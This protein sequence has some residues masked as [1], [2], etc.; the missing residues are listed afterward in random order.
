MFILKLA[1]ESFICL[2]EEG[3]GLRIL[4]LGGEGL[5]TW[6]SPGI[7]GI[8]ISSVLVLSKV[9]AEAQFIF[10]QLASL[11]QVMEVVRVANEVDVQVR[12][13]VNRLSALAATQHFLELTP[14]RLYLTSCILWISDLLISI[15]F[16]KV[17]ITCEDC[18]PFF[19]LIDALKLGSFLDAGIVFLLLLTDIIIVK[20]RRVVNSRH[21]TLLFGMA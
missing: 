10:S 15:L 16:N 3:V 14:R 13:R 21:S 11:D 7:C 12:W 2:S 19:S 1:R 9:H 18:A 20:A 8:E 6:K 5:C 17:V 4:F